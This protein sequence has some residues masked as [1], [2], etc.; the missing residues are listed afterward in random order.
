MDYS[1]YIIKEL[2]IIECFFF[3]SKHIWATNMR[4]WCRFKSKI[5]DIAHCM[6]HLDR[7]VCFFRIVTCIH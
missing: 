5:R 2:Y 1:L 6:Y 3:W 7:I 4:Y